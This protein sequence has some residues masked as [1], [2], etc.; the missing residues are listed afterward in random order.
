MIICFIDNHIV[1]ERTRI[2]YYWQNAA[3]R[4]R[5]RRPFAFLSEVIFQEGIVVDELGPNV[6]GKLDYKLSP[7]YKINLRNDANDIFHRVFMAPL[8]EAPP[9]AIPKEVSD[10][11][12]RN[13][14]DLK[15][16]DPA[17]RID[18]TILQK[19]DPTYLEI[20]NVPNR[21]KRSYFEIEQPNLLYYKE[22][23]TTPAE[24]PQQGGDMYKK[25]Y[26]KYKQKYLALKNK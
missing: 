1:V 3:E 12:I 14:A 10:Y 25:K 22:Q 24:L 26:L 6:Y 20:P 23:P 8:P 18:P 19:D 5:V 2:P 7:L 15:S 11:Y 17:I 4:I 16:I 21:P 9:E 13:I